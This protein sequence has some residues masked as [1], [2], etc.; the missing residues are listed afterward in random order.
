MGNAHNSNQYAVIWWLAQR[1]D[2]AALR[3]AIERVPPELRHTHLEYKSG[4][5]GST[6]LVV[7]VQHGHVECVRTLLATGVNA[8]RN[9]QAGASPLHVA[10][11][12]NYPAVAQL[13][14]ENATVNCNAM[15]RRGC[16]PLLVAA[17]EGH[18]EV[19]EVLLHCGA[20]DLFACKGRRSGNDVLALVR[21]AYNKAN[22]SSR[23]KFRDCLKLIATVLN[24]QCSWAVC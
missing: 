17:M 19:L 12:G 13:L 21:K 1:G 9:N 15:D 10:A 20:V 6:P 18:A 8:N 4:T 5:D 23:P 14:I 7:A 24:L 11:K 3:R 16:T 2:V 22:D